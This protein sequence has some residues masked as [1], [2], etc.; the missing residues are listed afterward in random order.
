MKALLR[1]EE[2]AKQLSMHITHLQGPSSVPG[3]HI[4]E[5]TP[6]YDYSS[7]ASNGLFWLPL[8]PPFICMYHHTDVHRHILKS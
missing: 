1:P 2:M 6:I 3:T 5:L 4:R 7:R 8:A